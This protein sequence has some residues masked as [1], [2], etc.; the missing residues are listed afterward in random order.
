M[1][2]ASKTRIKDI[3]KKA[4]HIKSTSKTARRIS[5]EAVAESLGAE[6][7]SPNQF[8]SSRSKLKKALGKTVPR[9][10]LHRELAALLNR[11]SAENDS[12]TPDFLLAEYLLSC[13]ATWNKA[14][15]LR[16]RWYGR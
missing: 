5:P 3:S 6:P 15:N 8:F 9:S 11:Y 13:L 10:E 12:D 1:T 4:K 2:K 16:D 7:A 14:T